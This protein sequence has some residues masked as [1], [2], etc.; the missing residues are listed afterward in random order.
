MQEL[1]LV[2][3]KERSVYILAVEGH[4]LSRHMSDM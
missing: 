1:K 4:L 3:R 2:S